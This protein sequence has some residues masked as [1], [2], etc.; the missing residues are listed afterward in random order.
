VA[1]A[2]RALIRLLPLKETVLRTIDTKELDIKKGS[3]HLIPTSYDQASVEYKH[4]AASLGRWSLS[5]ARQTQDEVEQAAKWADEATARKRQIASVMQS[6]Q[7]VAKNGP[8]AIA[9]KYADDKPGIWISKPTFKLSAE[10]G[11]VLYPLTA[12]NDKRLRSQP[13][14]T[15]VV[16]GLISIL[17]AA[18]MQDA[19]EDDSTSFKAI[20]RSEE[21]LLLY[22]FVAAPEQQSL[23]PGHVIPSLS[24]QV[25]TGDEESGAALH[26]AIL[27]FQQHVHTVLL[28]NSAVDVQFFRRGEMHLRKV[29]RDKQ[30]KEW[31]DAVRANIASGE[32]L[33][34]PDLSIKVPKWTLTGKPKDVKDGKTLSYLFAG[35]RFQQSVVGTFKGADVAYNTTQAGKMGA[36]GG[37]LNMYYDREEWGA[38]AL[39]QDEGT[40]ATFVEQSL[41][42]VDKITEAASATLPLAKKML[43]PR[44]M[45]S[46]RRHRRADE[47]AEAAAKT[48]EPADNAVAQASPSQ[49]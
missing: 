21:P 44:D 16:P 36:Q 10:F 4:R 8:P 19:R 34:A 39:L 40:L 47:Q 7:T 48:E 46:A 5:V 13:L 2:E 32:R 27:G 1:E 42:F 41:D 18:R 14:F 28:P 31:I 17:G 33:T 11:Q 37:S 22:D 45:D 26:K 49:S 35:V 25:R 38:E 43:R 23:E 20:K 24:I 12:Q 29:W 15:P 3:S 6:L 30:L 9:E